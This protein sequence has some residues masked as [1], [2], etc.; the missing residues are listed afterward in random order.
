MFPRGE[1]FR[2]HFLPITHR[3]G[4]EKLLEVLTLSM[5]GSISTHFGHG[6]QDLWGA[7]CPNG[8]FSLKDIPLRI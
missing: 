3:R 7:A 2:C 1:A 8:V 6:G 4:L 5:A